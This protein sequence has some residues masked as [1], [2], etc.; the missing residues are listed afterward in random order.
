MGKP[1]FQKE[2]F[3]VGRQVLGVDGVE[4]MD[5]GQKVR[6]MDGGQEGALDL[7]VAIKV[8]KIYPQPEKD[9]ICFKFTLDSLSCCRSIVSAWYE[10]E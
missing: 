2:C 7:T 3:K 10:S 5:C 9:N 6:L 4:D 8:L 1:H